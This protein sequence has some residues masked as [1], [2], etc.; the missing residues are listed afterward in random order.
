MSNKE[1]IQFLYPDANGGQTIIDPN[2]NMMTL[3][4]G[5]PAYMTDTLGRVWTTT[6]GTSN[7][8]GCPVYAVNATVWNT[9]GVNGGTRQFKLCYS[10]VTVTT[11]LPNLNGVVTRQ[12]NGPGCTSLFM[13]GVVLPHNTTWRFD[14]DNYGDVSTVYP[15]TGGTI[16]YTYTL[17]LL[18]TG[19]QTYVRTVST[20]T[21]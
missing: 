11:A 5:N 9:P 3:S 17:T 6:I 15:P 14:Y 4:T 12:C 16:S 8:N 19:G 21:V 10:Y 20:R 7:T 1:G 13:T 18:Q 2:G